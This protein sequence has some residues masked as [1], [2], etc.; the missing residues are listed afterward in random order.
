VTSAVLSVLALFAV[1]SAISVFTGRHAGR[2]GLRMAVIGILVA[3][4][5]F[6]V[7]KLVGVGVS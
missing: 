3:T 4:A 5:T 2:S 7:G 1:G 6:L